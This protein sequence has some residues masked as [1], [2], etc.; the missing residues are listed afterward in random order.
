ME[1]KPNSIIDIS[2]YWIDVT[3]PSEAELLALANTYSLHPN[4]VQDCLEPDHLPKYE[5]TGNSSF[6][7]LRVYDNAQASDAD[8]IQEVT[9]KIAIFV[10]AD[11]LITV[12]RTNQPLLEDIKKKYIDTQQ[13]D[14][15]HDLLLHILNAAY[16]SYDIPADKL[17]AEIDFYETRIFLKTKL[18]NLLKNLYHIKRKVSVIRRILT[19]SKEI[20]NKVEE[21][22]KKDAMYREM[23]DNYVQQVTV[24]DQ[25]NEDINNLLSLYLSISGQRTNEVIRVLTIFSVFFMPLTFIVGIYGM[26][27]DHMPELRWEYGYLYSMLAMILVTAIIYLWFKRKKWL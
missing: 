20:T 24:Y 25:L 23:R 4:A 22:F 7:V 21:G 10:I 12:H 1:A 14:D 3:N 15:K 27:F 6:L 5:E 26:N 11:K 19:L 18:P 9:R 16:L 8:T 2:N 13:C 17:I